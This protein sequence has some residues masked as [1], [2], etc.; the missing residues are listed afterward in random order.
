MRSG[1]MRPDLHRTWERSGTHRDEGLHETIRRVAASQPDAV[2]LVRGRTRRTY[3]EL[4]HAA[5]G[6]AARLVS[7][8][9]GAGRC[10]PILIPKS[11]ELVTALLAVLK[12]GA[13]YALL[14]PAWPA[15]RL[16]EV[17]GHL[18]APL[19]VTGPGSAG[20]AEAANLP[21]WTPPRRPPAAPPDFRPA[22]VDGS[23]PCCV[24]FTSG[25]TGQPKGVLTPH[26]ATARLFR[27]DS[28]AC[29]GASTVIPL[30]APMPWDAFSLELW[31]ALLN[32]GTSVLVDEP[33]LSAQSLPALIRAR[34][35]LGV[36]TVW[37]TSSLF[38]MVV[39]E[40]VD[41]FDGLQQALIG[42][43]R[44]SPA[45]V[46][47]FLRRHPSVTLL[48]GYGPV[49]STVF[50]TVHHITVADC[51][52]PGGIPLGLPVPGTRIFVLNGT[53]Q[54]GAGEEG[55][56]C[57]AGEGLAIGYLSDPG[58]TAIK[59]PH[60]QIDG[61]TVRV[62]RT[63]DLG[64]LDQE[65]LLHYR[66]RADRQVK[67]RGHRIEPAEVERQVE[68]L[69]PAVRACRVV[70]T[71]D[72]A[73]VPDGLAAF[74]V[75]VRP[76]DRLDGAHEALRRSLTHFHLPS[77]VVSVDRF[78]LTAQGK[79]DERALLA[80]LPAGG[81][82]AGGAV[83]ATAG[84]VDA[85]AQAVASAFGA[86]LGRAVPPDAS[87]F[88]LGGGSLDAG[89]VC[90]RLASRLNRPVP[91]SVLYRHPTVAALAAHL[92]SASRSSSPSGSQDG[93]DPPAAWTA[94]SPRSGAVPLTP[95][96]LV[97]LTRQLRGPADRTGHC[98]LTWT[99]HGELDRA[100]L[101]AAIAE[102]HGRHEPLRTAYVP[103]PSPAAVAVDIPPP[104]LEVL[105]SRPSIT[106][107]VEALRR[108]LGD[109]LATADGEIWRAGLVPVAGAAVALF[110]CVVHHIA[111]D[112]WSESILARDLAAAYDRVRGIARPATPRPPS[113]AA[114]YREY[115][116][117]LARIDHA[118]DLDRLADEL[119][120]VPDLS[121]PDGP[122]AG[123]AGGPEHLELT[124]DRTLLAR[125]EALAGDL[126]V[127]RFVVLLWCWVRGLAEVTGQHD[128]AVG[129]PVAQ[130]H[131]PG[132]EHAVGCHINML[133]IR[134]RGGALA[135]CR[136]GV[137][138]LAGIVRQAFGVQ[139][140]AFADLLQRLPRPRTG[141]PPLFQTLFALQDNQQPDLD[142]EGLRTSFL[143]QPYLDLPLELHA[144]LWPAAAGDLR[145]TVSFRPEAVREPV[146]A[147]CASRF[148][149]FLHESVAG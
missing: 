128:F 89:R 71:G 121:W 77:A 117:R 118:A 45:H 30:A 24:F 22:A 48:N 81:A 28:L 78:P 23:H 2:A 9:V 25:T 31:S 37:M 126:A 33:Y 53:R 116:S 10:V 16:R 131:G 64:R 149:E 134:I 12:A 70:V 136:R 39:E 26:R 54:C 137:Q 69:L 80:R 57:I 129:V 92:R 42:G 130:R 138:E 133:A 72:Q 35:P 29:F 60:L 122:R 83:G 119:A 66:G 106:A 38:N 120:N 90:A 44:L 115:R 132:M 107:A 144:E 85:T 139:E 62:Y 5:D 51:D 74:C 61:E 14:D 94:A 87:F 50:A 100:A 93:V 73:G 65:G 123:A 91:V 13:A 148:V 96:Q 140:V 110:G 75:P 86:V 105:A 58:Q 146:A 108:E 79:L 4:D 27:A 32:G 88:E 49:E 59:F 36:N 11:F 102:V 15:P 101:S 125:V 141:R 98:L 68:N 3:A 113:M 34:S 82:G 20:V 84:P 112:G 97:F 124:L 114:S 1:V 103:D 21:A 8:G 7:A 99:I 76:G 127:T 18:A 47:R 63:G 19:L 104:P 147:R 46:A 135:A 95:M 109:E 111:F 67:I 56:I 43:E 142:L 143:R 40:D 55:E 6:W 41:A 17:I 52:R 145:L